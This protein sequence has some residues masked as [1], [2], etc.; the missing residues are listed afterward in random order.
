M[1]RGRNAC[2]RFYSL[3]DRQI[4]K[5][6]CAYAPT[7]K[8]LVNLLTSG[9]CGGLLAGYASTR[10]AMKRVGSERRRFGYRR[11]HGMHYRQG[12]L[13]NL[14]TPRSFYCKV[15]CLSAWVAAERGAWAKAYAGSCVVSG[16]APQSDL[17]PRCLYRRIIAVVCCGCLANWIVALPDREAEQD[18]L[19]QRPEYAIHI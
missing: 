15:I 14:K 8:I 1:K 3:Q 10:G 19:R 17:H 6:H 7:I 2:R 16:R 18:R 12:L 5:S 9:R 13:M 11:I 4:C